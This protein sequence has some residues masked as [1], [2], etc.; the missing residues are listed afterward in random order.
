MSKSFS[1]FK[2]QVLERSGLVSSFSL[3]GNDVTVTENFDVYINKELINSGSTTLEEA[4][5]IAKRY[6][7][8]SKLLENIE[9]TIPSEKVV[10]FIRQYHKLDRIT[11]T[12][13][14]TYI[15]I[16]SSKSF[17]IDPVV[18]AIKESV[19]SEF[20]G[21]FDYV[22]EDG[23]VIAIDE[24]TQQV[25]NSLLADKQDIV[26]YMRESKN[27]FIRIIKELGEQDG[28]C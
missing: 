28:T 5:E 17:T 1:S 4:R 26:D 2:K 10:Q 7:E 9:T 12:L 13:V 18:I 16:V 21:K 14:E 20:V 24:S 23:S 25:L 22:L 11:D 27:N 6:I 15:D 3:Y 19:S 8:N